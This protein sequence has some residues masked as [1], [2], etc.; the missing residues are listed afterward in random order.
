MTSVFWYSISLIIIG[1]IG[2]LVIFEIKKRIKIVCFCV[3]LIGLIYQGIYV[4]WEKQENV[5]ATKE[6][7]DMQRRTL[8]NQYGI[9]TKLDNL[10]DEVEDIK[11]GEKQNLFERDPLVGIWTEL[12]SLNRTLKINERRS[13]GELA[14]IYYDEVNK[15]PTYFNYQE[16]QG[17]EKFIYAEIK[18]MIGTNAHNAEHNKKQKDSFDELR[19]RLLVAK[20]RTVNENKLKQ[21]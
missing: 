12:E 18:K 21:E 3:V 4:F 1:I 20:E 11:D 6:D 8:D 16:W 2:M 10:G 13:L 9:S 17:A 5:K 19:N 14:G 7:R 15:I